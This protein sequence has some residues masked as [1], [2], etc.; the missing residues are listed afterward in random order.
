MQYVSRII[1]IA[2]VLAVDSLL[3]Q[4]RGEVKKQ[5]KACA[6]QTSSMWELR[7]IWFQ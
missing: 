4:W 1:I 2:I 5:L 6:D 3:H 7:T